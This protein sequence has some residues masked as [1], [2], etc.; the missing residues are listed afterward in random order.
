M[1]DPLVI[2][3]T[4]VEAGQRGRADVPVMTLLNG[5]E[6]SL[7]IHA[8]HGR[9]DGPTICLL[10]TLHGGEWFS[11][12]ALRRVTSLLDPDALRG[13]VLVVPVANPLAFG[14]GTRDTPGNSDSPDMNRSFGGRHTWSSDQLADAV[15]T[16]AINR[17][18][19][20]L[21]FHMGPWGSAFQDILIGGDFPE[22]AAEESERLALAFGSPVIRRADIVKGFPGP[23]SSIGY[24][25][26]VRGIPAMGIEIGGAG[27]SPKLEEAWWNATVDGILAVLGAMSM[28]DDPPD[29]RPA[30][31]LIYRTSHRVNPRH[32]GLLRSR[33]GGDQLGATVAAGTLLGEVLSPYSNEVIEELRAPAEGL[34]F[35]VARDYPVEPGGWA[36]GLA[37]VAD[38]A[39]WIE[40]NGSEGVR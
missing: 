40:R 3:S 37:S 38:G 23:R 21:D 17:S 18:D 19:C 25:G 33:F 26:G 24:A 15:T 29:P 27:F 36:Y 13:T 11:I 31:Q 28:I 7:S 8:I 14:L 20:L 16:H 22:P 2:G 12:E 10:S 6:L 30:R 5:S 34:L 9:E 35:Y 32:G 1:R 39:R 4:S